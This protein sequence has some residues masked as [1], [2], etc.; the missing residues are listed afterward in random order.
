MNG[1]GSW[2]T[3]ASSH[4]WLSWCGFAFE[5][6]CLKHVYQIKR[7]LSIAGMHSENYVWRHHP[8]GEEQGAQIDLLIDRADKCM[9]VCEIKFAKTEFEITKKYAGEL[10]NKLHVFQ[11]RT[12]TRKTLF[13]TLVTTHGVKNLTPYAGLVQA[14]VTL[15][16]LFQEGN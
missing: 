3:F 10:Q 4:S 2:A 9:N 6:I 8:Q 14:Q 16:A 5:H 11:E 1:P 7:A 15:D 13:L 12:K